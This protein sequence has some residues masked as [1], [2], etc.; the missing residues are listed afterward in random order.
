MVY[1]HRC[2]LWIKWVWC[3]IC[4]RWLF[5]SRT[6]HILGKCV[7]HLT[8]WNRGH[9]READGISAFES[10]S[11]LLWTRRFNTK[12]CHWRLFRAWPVQLI[13]TFIFCFFWR[14]LHK[15]S[16]LPSGF[17]FPGFPS[18]LVFAV[19]VTCPAVLMLSGRRRRHRFN[20]LT[21]V[22]KINNKI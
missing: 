10:V 8:W 18:F 17:F 1:L 4:V 3:E 20:F 15:H 7:N 21:F 12:I 9:S 13:P 11:C 16:D 6:F 14:S 22:C 5:F 2:L 19:R